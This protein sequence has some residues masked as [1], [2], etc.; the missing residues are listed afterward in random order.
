MQNIITNTNL[1]AQTVEQL[2][3]AV[4]GLV[5]DFQLSSLPDANGESTE[6]FKIYRTIGG[7]RLLLEAAR[8]LYYVSFESMMSDSTYDYLEHSIRET[9][10][11][12]KLPHG[13]KIED[14]VGSD[15]MYDYSAEAKVFANLYQEALQSSSSRTKLRHTGK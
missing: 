3:M 13:R 4:T 8:Y 5:I 1:R 15:S 9:I 12:L 10:Q 2:R 6:E 7:M 14:S 11:D